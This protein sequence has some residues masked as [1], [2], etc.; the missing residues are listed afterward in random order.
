M[1]DQYSCF[2][3]NGKDNISQVVIFL[4]FVDDDTIIMYNSHDKYKTKEFTKN[5]FSNYERNAITNNSKFPEII[6]SNFP[7]TITDKIETFQYAILKAL[8]MTNEILLEELYLYAMSS[9]TDS[10][11]VIFSKLTDNE[12]VT[13]SNLMNFLSNVE[14]NKTKS[15]LKST[16]HEVYNFSEFEK[17]NLMKDAKREKVPLTILNKNIT[18]INPYKALEILN[19]D[20]THTDLKSE[21]VYVTHRSIQ[22][23]V[24]LDNTSTITIYCCFLESII[25]ESNLH[26]LTKDLIKQYFPSMQNLVSREELNDYRDRNIKNASVLNKKDIISSLLESKTILTKY[27]NTSPKKWESDFKKQTSIKNMRLEF[28]PKSPMFISLETLFHALELNSQ[29][30]L[31]KYNPGA[32][33]EKYYRINLENTNIRKSFIL[34]INNELSRAKKRSVSCLLDIKFKTSTIPMII[35]IRENGFVYI[36]LQSENIVEDKVYDSINLYLTDIEDILTNVYNNFIQFINDYYHQYNSLLPKFDN[37]YQDNLHIVEANIIKKHKIKANKFIFDN[38]N[39]YSPLIKNVFENIDTKQNSYVKFLFKYQQ[40]NSHKIHVLFQR[41]VLKDKAFETIVQNISHFDLLAPIMI[42]F[43]NLLYIAQENIQLTEHSIIMNNNDSEINTLISQN[44][45]SI[46]SEKDEI[47]MMAYNN[48]NNNNNNNNKI[49]EIEVP[50]NSELADE[51]DK[52]LSMTKPLTEEDDKKLSLTNNNKS[53]VNVISQKIPEKKTLLGLKKQINSNNNDDFFGGAEVPNLDEKRNYTYDRIKQYDPNLV[54]KEKQNNK[55]Y[56]RYCLSSERRQPTIITES[57]K[58]EIDEEAPGS[59]GNEAAHILNY[60][61][62]DGENLYYICPRYWCVDKNISLKH[63]DVTKTDTKLVSSKCPSGQIISYE[64]PLYHFKKGDKA[65]YINTYPGLNLKKSSIPCCFKKPRKDVP[66]INSDN[67]NRT[68]NSTKVEGLNDIPSEKQ[69][70]FLAKQPKNVDEEETSKNIRLLEYNKVPLP[71]FRYGYLPLNIKLMLNVKVDDCIEDRRNCLLRFGTTDEGNSSFLNTMH[72]YYNFKND[73]KRITKSLKASIKN[74]EKFKDEIINNWLTIDEFL[75]YQNGHLV[76]IFDYEEVGG[77]VDYDDTDLN[78]SVILDAITNDSGEIDKTLQKKILNAFSNYKTYLSTGNVDY[79]YTWELFTN[80]LN[81]VEK[82]KTNIIIIEVDGFEVESP[83]RIICPHNYKKN[84]TFNPRKPSVIIMKHGN[85]YEG[86]I[87]RS[88]YGESKYYN[89]VFFGKSDTFL[90]PFLSKIENIYN[91]NDFCGKYMTNSIFV[92]EFNNFTEVNPNQMQLFLDQN[93]FT[94]KRYIVNYNTR[95]CGFVLSH[96]SQNRDFFIP[97]HQ[98]GVEEARNNFK[99]KRKYDLLNHVSEYLDLFETLQTFNM[100][101]E[102]QNTLSY[103]PKYFVCENNYVVGIQFE[104]TLIV[105]I[106]PHIP[107]ETIPQ[108][109]MLDC[110][111]NNYIYMDKNQIHYY[112]SKL[113]ASIV[114]KQSQSNIL[115]DDINEKSK[116]YDTYRSH[117]KANI[118]KVENRHIK[119]QIKTI[120]INTNTDNYAD[121]LEEIIKFIKELASSNKEQIKYNNDEEFDLYAYKMSDELLRYYR[122]RDYIFVDNKYILFGEKYFRPK[123]NELLI[124][125]SSLDTLNEELTIKG[126]DKNS[127]SNYQSS[128]PEKLMKLKY[129]DGFNILD[130]QAKEPKQQM[131]QSIKYSVN[132]KVNENTKLK[133][134]KN[135]R[136]KCANG[137]RK[138]K[139]SGLCEEKN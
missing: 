85:H 102:M 16:K 61:K 2:I 99:N 54:K 118:N 87:Q 15:K 108:D 41:S 59:Y 109:Y 8:N 70:A 1:I 17:L 113:N 23:F 88:R 92:N 86:L 81:Q 75:N 129:D 30:I 104:N 35:E 36:S 133:S 20:E 91:N 57:E 77:K 60:R 21:S 123:E 42:M 107:K 9:I 37:L 48:N 56:S 27:L 89:K 66:P 110:V 112:D 114:K 44:N 136:E 116:N 119:H 111:K 6:Y 83:F 33:L 126:E 93:N 7:L 32:R 67:V 106:L 130:Y 135:K 43:D 94:I 22:E 13:K 11:D 139:K 29:T 50:G 28:Q 14:F 45:E 79:K 26:K 90:E 65:K 115:L 117:I 34:K 39:K 76:E 58:R 127:H 78:N 64:H 137:T 40:Y 12:Y 84:E 19:E 46:L 82:S 31:I 69:D 18:Y 38:I 53:N 4:P 5:Y 73:S 55:N 49:N 100:I 97:V 25:Q 124:G 121:V 103:K 62:R 24:H 138:N 3:L 80:K 52:E 105:P 95:L 125:Q 68:I 72:M 128:E 51:G 101:H 98:S 63:Q 122:I 96:E 131:F 71:E 10:T 120:L 47:E 74:I 134:K 132:S